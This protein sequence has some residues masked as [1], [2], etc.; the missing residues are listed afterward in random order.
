MAG[1]Q[2]RAELVTRTASTHR[3]RRDSLFVV[4]KTGDG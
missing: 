2:R 1:R 3:L 4:L